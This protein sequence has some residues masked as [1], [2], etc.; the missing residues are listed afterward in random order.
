MQIKLKEYRDDLD[1]DEI[2]ISEE[3]ARISG[4][5]KGLDDLKENIKEFGLIQPVT[6]YKKGERYQLLV[7]QRRFL[8]CKS[9]GKKTIRAFIINPMDEISRT[10]IS[11]GENV[12]RK[13]LPYEDSIQVCTKLFKHHSG[14]KKS[15]VQRIA[16]E[17]GISVGDV[18][19]YLQHELVPKEVRKLV[20]EEKITETFAYNVTTAHFPDTEKI[21]E[22][23][24]LALKMT[25]SESNRAV[26]YSKN[27]PKA[28]MSKVLDYARNPPPVVKLV[29]HIEY[30]TMAKIKSISKKRRLTIEKFAKNAISKSLKEE[31]KNE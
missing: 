9:L 16:K 2:D 30:D 7:G 10:I 29:L 31:E 18:S 15:K 4:A 19:K 3:N 20:D 26:E 17:L 14:T 1:I 24:K 11:F 12:H 6:V 13:D 22:I 21:I 28:K 8:A 5:A 23:T 25:S 27:N